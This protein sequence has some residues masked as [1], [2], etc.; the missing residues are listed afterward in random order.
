MNKL[1]T[2]D[3]RVNFGCFDEP[4]NFNNNDFKLT[5]LLGGKK[6]PFGRKFA[7]GGFNFIGISSD[8]F[9][10]GIGAV[11]LGYLANVFGF[12]YEFKNGMKHDFSRMIL[13]S[14][15][16]FPLN[17]DESVIT[18]SSRGV[19]YSVKK[20]HKKNSLLIDC[21]F[22]KLL[23]IKAECA[24]GF[25]NKPL[26]VLNPSCGDP[27][28]F[29]FTEK[30][31]LIKPTSL[32]I[33]VNGRPYDASLKRTTVFYDW[34]A[35]F[36]NRYTHW[37]WSAFSG[38]SKGVRVG[39]NFAAMVNETFYPENAYWI[40]GKRIRTA[41][42]IFDFDM[43]DPYRRAWRIFT[44]DGRVNLT[45]IPYGERSKK[46]NVHFVKLF[47]RQ[48]MGE[49]SGTLKDSSGKKIRIDGLKGISEIHLSKW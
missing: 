25:K 7:A 37:F 27:T 2:K 19:V 42:V 22:K 20:S 26:R 30:C 41:Q 13:P 3:N 8:D 39:A 11:Q 18:Y 4:I 6:S 48:F 16:K 14:S 29:T 31:P 28:R 33:D 9:I 10:A 34:S 1:V 17:P 15:L 40:N 23:S 49:Y 36:F 46:V 44:E 24:Y 38:E 43:N 47:F 12:L 35:G 32:S 5:T 45:F 21:T